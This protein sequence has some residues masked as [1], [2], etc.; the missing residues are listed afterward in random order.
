VNADQWIEKL[1]QQLTVQQVQ[2]AFKQLLAQGKNPGGGIG[3]FRLLKHLI[4]YPA[5]TD[6]DVVQIFMR[7][8]IALKRVLSDIPTIYYFEAD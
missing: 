8:K 7:I 1:S 6:D 3:G 4:A 2:T 5:V